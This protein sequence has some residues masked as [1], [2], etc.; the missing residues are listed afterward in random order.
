MLY[1]QKLFTADGF[2]QK[3]L[4]ELAAPVHNEEELQELCKAFD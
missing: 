1:L 4:R 3:E 2:D